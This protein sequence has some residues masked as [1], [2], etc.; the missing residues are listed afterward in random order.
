MEDSGS[1]S[2]GSYFEQELVVTL[3]FLVP[4]RV[5]LGDVDY[6]IVGVF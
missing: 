4:Q 2:E 6:I 3:E 1:E 5:A